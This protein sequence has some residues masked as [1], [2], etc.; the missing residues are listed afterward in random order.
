MAR[1]FVPEGL[2]KDV[3]LQV[4]AT[5]RDVD[6]IK[7]SVQNIRTTLIVLKRMEGGDVYPESKTADILKAAVQH[8]DEFLRKELAAKIKGMS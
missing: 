7:T 6:A 4:R 1:P 3:S 5:K 2:K 8:Y